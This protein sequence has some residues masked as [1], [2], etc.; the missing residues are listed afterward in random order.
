MQASRGLRVYGRVAQVPSI[1][2]AY[3][4]LRRIRRV[5]LAMTRIVDFAD[6]SNVVMESLFDDD[7]VVVA[8]MGNPWT[9]RRRIDL[10]EL[11]NE[12]W[13]LPP[14]EATIGTFAIDAFRARGLKP[15][16]TAVITKQTLGDRPLSHDPADLRGNVLRQAACS[17]DIAGRIGQCPRDDRNLRVEESNAQPPCRAVHQDSPC[18]REVAG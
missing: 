13:T 2:E 3:R 12:P 4:V 17:Q 18:R 15:P 9:R 8:A 7:F 16:R 6:Q 11:V 1:V 5:E 14:L 10:A